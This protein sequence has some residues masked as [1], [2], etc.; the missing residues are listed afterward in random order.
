MKN[1]NPEPDSLTDDT[2]LA[3]VRRANLDA[4]WSRARGTVKGNKGTIERTIRDVASL[5][6][7]GP[8]YDNGPTPAI[9]HAGYETAIALLVDTRRPRTHSSTHKQWD[10]SRRVKSAIANFE[11]ATSTNTY[12]NLAFVDDNKGSVA[13]LMCIPTS[14]FWFQRFSQGCRARMGQVTKQNLA[15]TVDLWKRMLEG[16]EER[17]FDA[18]TFEE[19]ARWTIAGAYLALIYVLSLR[20]PEGFQIEIS[21]LKKY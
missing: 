10:S 19:A 16:V 14:S 9:D 15:L 8:F 7:V 3:Y 11:R 13:R 4:F 5:G 2:L 21:L 17:M 12:N 18:E 1:R 6:L 20:G